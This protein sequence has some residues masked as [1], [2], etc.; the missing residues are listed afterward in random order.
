MFIK[1]PFR[2]FVRNSV[3]RYDSRA[4]KENRDAIASE[5]KSKMGN[6]LKGSLFQLVSLVVG[7]IDYPDIIMPWFLTFGH[8]IS[9]V[10]KEK[11][12]N[13]QVAYCLYVNSHFFVPYD[14]EEGDIDRRDESINVLSI[15]Y[16]SNKL[17]I[18]PYG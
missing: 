11:Q 15:V 14:P 5:V 7:N 10:Y 8:C 4:I 9:W 6:H 3:Q 13:K 16:V 2:T 18:F 12:K 17:I 1:E